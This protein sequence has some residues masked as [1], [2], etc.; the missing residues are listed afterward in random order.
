MLEARI[1]HAIS[2][3]CQGADPITTRYIQQALD[4]IRQAT[5]RGQWS[6][7]AKGG[8]GDQKGIISEVFGA[9]GYIVDFEP[10]EFPGWFVAIISWR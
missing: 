1:A 9:L 3:A 6:I 2:K 7:R 8:S 5:I 10:G 4:D